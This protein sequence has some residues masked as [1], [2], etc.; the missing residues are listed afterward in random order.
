MDWGY[1]VS[2]WVL[3]SVWLLWGQQ[4]YRYGPIWWSKARRPQEN[5]LS[6]SNKVS[7]EEE[8]EVYWNILVEERNRGAKDVL[9]S[10]HCKI[11]RFVWE[12]W[13]L[14]YCTGVHGRKWPLRLPL[15]PKL[16]TR[17]IPSQRSSH[18]NWQSR[19]LST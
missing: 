18:A 5:R 9:A 8:Y 11:S 6:C 19:G 4:N 3:K 13:L 2:N 10:K 15:A 14:L 7:E 12:C 17:R 1:S 16:Q